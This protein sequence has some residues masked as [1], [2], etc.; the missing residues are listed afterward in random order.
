LTEPKSES[1]TGGAVCEDVLTVTVQKAARSI[2]KANL[3]AAA[4]FLM[5][6]EG[7]P[8]L[9]TG[10]MERGVFLKILCALSRY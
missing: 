7:R 6:D 5:S 9:F 4:L 3:S 1:K 8:V 2:Y 10:P